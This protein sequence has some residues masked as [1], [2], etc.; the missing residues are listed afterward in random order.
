MKHVDNFIIHSVIGQGA[1]GKVFLCSYKEN[2]NKKLLRKL[3]PNR[4]AACKQ[5]ALQKTMHNKKLIKYL[6]SEID[7]MME[8]DHSNV[9]SLID[10]KKTNIA[11]L[12]VSIQFNRLSL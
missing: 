6:S 5:I 8:I 2:K 1:Y 7:V 9:L 3:K 10:A 12:A 4:T 11:M